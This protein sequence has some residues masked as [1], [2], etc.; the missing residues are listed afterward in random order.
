MVDWLPLGCT[1]FCICGDNGGVGDGDGEVSRGGGSDGSIEG[2]C[3]DGG[4]NNGGCY[5][6]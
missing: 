4:L 1:L 5:Y 3:N 6:Q 2:I